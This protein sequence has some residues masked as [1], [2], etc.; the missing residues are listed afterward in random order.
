MVRGWDKRRLKPRRPGGKELEGELGR[1][2]GSRQHLKK[3]CFKGKQDLS[4]DL[5]IWRSVVDKCA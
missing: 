2:G 3:A 5:M 4:L 1:K